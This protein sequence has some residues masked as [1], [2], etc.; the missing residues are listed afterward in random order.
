MCKF[1]ATPSQQPDKFI[2]YGKGVARTSQYS[3]IKN[4]GWHSTRTKSCKEPDSSCS[5]KSIFHYE[6][7]GEYIIEP[8]TGGRAG[9]KYHIR[10]VGTLSICIIQMSMYKTFSQTNTTSSK[11]LLKMKQPLILEFLKRRRAI[12]DN[13]TIKMI[14]GKKNQ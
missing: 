14:K 3:P 6:A 1:N 13:K 10:K 5:L 12:S 7:I 2:L 4:K 8:T 11:A 9:P